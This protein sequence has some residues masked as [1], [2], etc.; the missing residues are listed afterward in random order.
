MSECCT[1]NSLV[2]L[3][4]RA[5]AS[6][7]PG[8]PCSLGSTRVP[9]CWRASPLH[10]LSFQELLEYRL[11]H[12]LPPGR[13]ESCPAPRGFGICSWRPADKFLFSG[14]GT[15]AHWL[16]KTTKPHPSRFSPMGQGCE[17]ASLPSHPYLSLKPLSPSGLLRNCSFRFMWGN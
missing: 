12:L 5:G 1:W 10:C 13:D 4:G 15:K 8:S 9:P 2:G 14:W 11:P 6:R 7:K 17:E 16:Y 3:D